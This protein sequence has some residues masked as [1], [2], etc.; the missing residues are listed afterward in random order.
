[1]W[2]SPKVSNKIKDCAREKIILDLKNQG[3]IWQLS[4][5]EPVIL[6]LIRMALEIYS[7]SYCHILLFQN[8]FYKITKEHTPEELK[9]LILEAADKDRIKFER[10]KSKYYSRS[11]MDIKL[12]RP[13]IF[14]E[15]RIAVWRRDEGKCVRCGSRENLEYDH[16]IPISQGGSNTVRNIELLCE[17]CNRTKSNNIQ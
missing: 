3:P 16:I 15:V 14:E 13:R 4:K 8:C 12:N 9:L 2:N 5:S 17:K 10:L 6:T 1:M 11:S 7:E